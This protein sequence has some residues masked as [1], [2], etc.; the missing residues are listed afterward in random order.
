MEFFCILKRV[1]GRVENKAPLDI[2][3]GLIGY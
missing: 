3:D 1:P 2:R